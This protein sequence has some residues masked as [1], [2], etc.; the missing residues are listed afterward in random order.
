M[1]KLTGPRLIG[2]LGGPCTGKTT[3]CSNLLN[4][5]QQQNINAGWTKEFVSDDIPVNG[6]PPFESLVYEQF[7]FNFMQRRR[8]LEYLQK[9][10]IVITDAPLLLGYAYALQN[11]TSSY[12]A[13]QQR[14]MQDFMPLFKE[15]AKNYHKLYFLSREF[16]YEDNGIR[17]HTEEQAVD[18]DQHLKALLKET[19]ID[20]TLLK[21]SV[22]ERVN[23]VLADMKATSAAA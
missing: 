9:H 6:A 16:P 21:G 13:R 2:F 17:F 8:E 14:L 4:T 1:T 23:T 18:F 11:E 19:G 5:L 10:D 7:R 15:D 20:Y 3:I 12:C 22:E